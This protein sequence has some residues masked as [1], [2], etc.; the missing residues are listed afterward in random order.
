MTFPNNP[1]LFL[2]HCHNLEYEDDG[3][4]LQFQSHPGGMK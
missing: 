4:M 2:L 1:G 3:M